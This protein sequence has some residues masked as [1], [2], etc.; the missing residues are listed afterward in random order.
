MCV[1]GR[2]KR[3][4]KMLIF[5][6]HRTQYPARCACVCVFVCTCNGVQTFSVENSIKPVHATAVFSSIQPFKTFIESYLCHSGPNYM[7]WEDLHSLPCTRTSDIFYRWVLLQQVLRISSTI[8]ILHLS[9]WQGWARE[10][11]QAHYH[12]LLN[13]SAGSRIAGQTPLQP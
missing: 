2:E 7:W 1:W 12:S 6:A 4:V 10:S 8:L 9:K 3:R 13:P 5:H 11:F